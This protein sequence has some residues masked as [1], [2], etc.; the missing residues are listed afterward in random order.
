MSGFLTM[1]FG[2]LTTLP[3]S[4]A[5]YWLDISVFQLEKS[6]IYCIHNDIYYLGAYMSFILKCYY[7]VCFYKNITPSTACAIA[8]KDCKGLFIDFCICVPVI[9][10]K[11]IEPIG[12]GDQSIRASRNYSHASYNL[13]RSYVILSW[14]S[15]R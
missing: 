7:F 11:K 10:D 8:H 9:C 15:R 4:Y 14:K 5:K 1:A 2:F 3:L 13:E 6:S 12:Q